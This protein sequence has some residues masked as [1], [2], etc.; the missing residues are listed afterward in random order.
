MDVLKI[1]PPPFGPVYPEMGNTVAKFRR[2]AA[3]AGSVAAMDPA[4]RRE[5]GAAVEREIH[6]KNNAWWR[7][8]G[9]LK[10][11]PAPKRGDVG[12]AIRAAHRAA[13]ASCPAQDRAKRSVAAIEAAYE[14][15]MAEKRKREA[16][17]IVHAV[18]VPVAPLIVHTEPVPA[19]DRGAAARKAWATRRARAAKAA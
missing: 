19:T 3:A 16:A 4:L 7:A 12:A 14:A 5:Y 13:L 9:A 8:G 11:P 10:V 17:P 1:P 15:A 18:P 6:A 2:M